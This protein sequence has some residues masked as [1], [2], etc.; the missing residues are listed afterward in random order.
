ME[1]PSVG[2]GAIIVTVKTFVFIQPF[3]NQYIDPLIWLEPKLFKKGVLQMVQEEAARH[4]AMIW[5]NCGFVVRRLS[6]RL[7]KNF[8][9]STTLKLV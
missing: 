4:L 3:N 6:R 8:W 5:C 7:E 2:C 9:S 1:T